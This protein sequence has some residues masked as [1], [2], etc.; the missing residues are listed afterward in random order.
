MTDFDAVDIFTDES[1]IEDPYPYFEHLRAQCPVA[2]LRAREGVVGVTGYDEAM[3]IYRDFETY[4]SISSGAGPFLMLSEPDEDNVDALIEEQRENVRS[5]AGG[6]VDLIM[7]D[8]PE[9]TRER[10]VLMRLLTPKRLR[11]NEDF[12]WRHADTYLDAMLPQGRCEFIA[13]YSRPFTY[14]VIADLLGVPEEVHELFRS[15]LELNAGVPG[16]VR[17]SDDRDRDEFT[18]SA[19]GFGFLEEWFASFLDDRRREPKPDVLTDIALAKYPDGSTPPL[20]RITRT[21]VFLFLAGTETSARLLATCLRQLAEHPE[22]QDRLREDR[23]LI[24][25]FVEEA[26]RFESPVKTDS[27][28]VRRAT[29]LA[30]V[31]LPVGTCVSIFLGAANRDPRQFESPDE[32]R[33]DRPHAQAHLAFGRG[34][35]S[36]PGGPL[37]RAEA[38]ISVGR[39]LDR[40][41]DIRLSEE[42][43]GPPGARRFAYAPTYVLRGLEELHLEF[44]PS[45]P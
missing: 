2:A 32:F 23:D 17:E 18:G 4:S 16:D 19:G 31:E 29:T 20:D 36:C 14:F 28:T 42:H 15:R 34:I 6:V 38:R 41:R 21:A 35:H 26:L 9:H 39:I 22:L 45:V 44:T 8:P 7:L 24:P 10:G 11:E 40:M 30:G 5:L 37:A 43:H 1:L 12:M 33:V 27:R 25:S 13:E 3:A